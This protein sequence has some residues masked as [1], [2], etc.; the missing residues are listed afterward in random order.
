MMM[1]FVMMPPTTPY[2]DV[3]FFIY[4]YQRWIYPMDPHRV[5]EFGTSAED[6]QPPP[7]A[8]E[9]VASEGGVAPEESQDTVE[10]TASFSSAESDVSLDE[11]SSNETAELRRRLHK[12][13]D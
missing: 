2:L 11:N 1:S 9:G 6:Q 3:V 12:R 13:E 10:L 5:N 8:I 4:L 7:A